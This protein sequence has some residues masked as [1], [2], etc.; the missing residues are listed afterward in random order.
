MNGF[1]KIFISSL[2][3]LF[4]ST[5]LYASDMLLTMPPILAAATIEPPVP[6]SLS[7]FNDFLGKGGCDPIWMNRDGALGIAPY[8]NS[9]GTCNATFT[10][11]DRAHTYN[12]VLTVQTEFDGQSPYE[13][14]INDKLIKKDVFP[15]SSPLGC[16][17][18]LD[19][20]WYICPDRNVNINLGN[21][22]LKKGD[23]IKFR[24]L[25]VYPCGEHGSYAKWHGMSFTPVK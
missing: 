2:L 9:W 11:V 12:I 18:P 13:V 10:G 20:W 19:Q 4:S 21:F 17:C 7:A 16:G 3:V 6:V 14:Y 22:T 25:D 23:V 15:L 5:S 8:S 1:I 24:G